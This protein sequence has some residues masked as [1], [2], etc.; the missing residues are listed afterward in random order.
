VTK[1]NTHNIHAPGEIR[2][3][4]SSQRTGAYPHLRLRDHWDLPSTGYYV[5]KSYMQVSY[6]PCVEFCF[7]DFKRWDWQP[8]ACT[9]PS[10]TTYFSCK[11]D[12]VL[13]LF[14][15]MC[16][17]SNLSRY[18]DCLWAG[19]SGDRI[20]VGARFFAQVQTGP[21][22][23]PTSCTMGTGSFPGVKRPGRGTDHPTL[24]ASRSRKDRAIPVST[25]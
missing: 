11:Y 3:V 13:N 9:S 4:N 14:P 22:A 15:V 6:S 12:L 24:L 7:R 20:P 25:L 19:R 23:H 17:L 21:G 10:N 18:S 2:T 16:L 5:Y 8:T 1:H